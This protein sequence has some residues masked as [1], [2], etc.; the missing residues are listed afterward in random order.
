MPRLRTPLLLVC[1]SASL[2]LPARADLALANAKNCLSCHTID[3]KILGPAYQD[4]ATKYRGDKAAAAFLA[5]KI[6][7]GG[8]GVWGV[9]KMP[10]NPQVSEAEAKK[11][12]EWVL[13]L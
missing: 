4:I 7:Q 5:S 11:L 2:S 12:A 1:L 6:R 13:G 10:S 3:K 9:V 8:G